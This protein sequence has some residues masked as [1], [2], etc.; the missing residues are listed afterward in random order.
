[1]YV[2]VMVVNFSH[3]KIQLPKATVLCVAEETS[4]SV[5]A[6]I[7]DEVITNFNH[8]MKIHCGVN[9]ILGDAD[10]EQYLQDM[11][12]HLSHAD[13]SVMEPVLR[14]YRHVFHVHGINDF[15][16][17]DLIEDRIVTGD[18]KPIRKS[19]YRVPFAH[20]NEMDKQV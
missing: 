15:R 5:V 1:M 10:F 17:T 19:P 8:R 9:T 6:D 12:G 20:R 16:S 2:H 3:E 11:L 14:K 13:R 4:A 18:A 7:N